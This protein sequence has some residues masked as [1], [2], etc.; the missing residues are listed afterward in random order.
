MLMIVGQLSIMG[1]FPHQEVPLFDIGTFGI[2]PLAE[3]L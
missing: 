1:S 3:A 2:Y